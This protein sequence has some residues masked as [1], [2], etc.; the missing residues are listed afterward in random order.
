M[1]QEHMGTVSLLQPCRHR[2][3]DDA[4]RFLMQLREVTKAFTLPFVNISP[5]QTP[6]IFDDQII[7]RFHFALSGVSEHVD[8]QPR[9]WRPEH[10]RDA[11]PIEGVC[12]MR[13][14]QTVTEMWRLQY[15]V[16]TVLSVL[17]YHGCES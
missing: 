9:S 3:A 17:S 7:I 5:R 8:L 2:T 14:Q 16:R 1:R 15:L 12:S 10:V 4:P 11:A 6:Q 13:L